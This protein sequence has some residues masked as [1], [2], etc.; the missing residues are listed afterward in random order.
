MFRE[1]FGTRIE[2]RSPDLLLEPA[3]YLPAQLK[4][5]E[6]LLVALTIFTREVI[7][8]LA[9]ARNHAQ[10]PPPGREVLAVIREVLGQV[11]DPLGE[12][13][14]LHIGTPGITFVKLEIL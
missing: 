10:K 8:Q 14:N 2:I 12:K 11:I 6:Q 5:S 3:G 7:E 9:A 1:F 4:R 13:C